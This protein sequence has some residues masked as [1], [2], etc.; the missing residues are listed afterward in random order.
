MIHNKTIV[1]FSISSL[2]ILFCVHFSH[3][4][5][6]TVQQYGLH[7]MSTINH[8]TLSVLCD[9]TVTADK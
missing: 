4:P 6:H 2:C 7:G 9:Y 5:I 1:L 8:M 3:F